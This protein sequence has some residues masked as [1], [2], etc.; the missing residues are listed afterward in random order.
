MKKVSVPFYEY[1][2]GKSQVFRDMNQLRMRI[3]KHFPDGD[4]PRQIRFVIKDVVPYAQQLKANVTGFGGKERKILDEV[5]RTESLVLH[6]EVQT[7]D[8]STLDTIITLVAWRDGRAR[9]V[10]VR[11]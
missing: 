5:L 8:G 2:D 11:D 7:A 3:E 6:Q 9:I 1:G 4:D 10:G